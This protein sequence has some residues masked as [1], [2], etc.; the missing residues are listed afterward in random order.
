MIKHGR[1]N[2][3]TYR[4][5]QKMKD[6]CINPNNHAWI[7][8]GSKGIKICDHWLKFENFL[9]DIGERPEGK[10]LDRIDNNGNY[11]PGNCR[12]ATRKEQARNRNTS[13]LSEEEVIR[14]KQFL[15][16][17]LNQS[18]IATEFNVSRKTISD[19]NTE[20]IWQ[21]IKY[22]HT[23]LNYEDWSLI[24][25]GFCKGVWHNCRTIDTVASSY[26]PFSAKQCKVCKKDIPE[27]IL[28]TSTMIKDRSN[29]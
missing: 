18:K 24:A 19:I 1:S 7:Y 27:H 15:T 23:I 21:D 29:G 5:W 20:K 8:Y 4:S 9:T 12:W 28:V 11:E 17:D 3:P 16:K 13:K 22:S 25:S 6:R 2:T 10:T 26:S 14:I